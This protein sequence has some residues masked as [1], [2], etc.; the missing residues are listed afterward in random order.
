MEI[1]SITNKELVIIGYASVYNLIDHHNDT[2]VK[3]A[4]QMLLI[5]T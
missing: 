2:L 1:K 5:I 3:G 4:L